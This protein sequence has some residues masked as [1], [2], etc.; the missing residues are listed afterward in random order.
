MLIKFKKLDEKAVIPSY[1]R[2]GDAGLDLVATSFQYE[3]NGTMVSYG[4]G[5][6]V[7]IPEGFL[8]Y[9]MPRSSIC[10]YD[11]I[12]SNSMGLIDSNY[13]GEIKAKFKCLTDNFRF[14]K[15]GDRICQLVI[16]PYPKITPI[17]ALELSETN[18]N[19][20]GFGSSGR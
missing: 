7:E 4:V 9:V 11:L 17:E 18:R 12:L 2:E 14:Y 16:M 6:A 19:E 13:R 10:N 15:I 1:Q 3:D 5:L 20:A 8:G